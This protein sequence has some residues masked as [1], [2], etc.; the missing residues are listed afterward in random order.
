MVAK[1][2]W[3][4]ARTFS[5]MRTYR[6]ILC[7]IVRYRSWPM[8]INTCALSRAFTVE[9]KRL[10]MSAQI[11]HFIRHGEGYHNV[12]GRKSTEEYKKE[13]YADAHLTEL[14]WTQV[15]RYL[16]SRLDP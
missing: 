4:I 6:C 12:A 9:Y 7:A 16:S 5:P 1:I 2:Q 14:G 11:V 8:H 13:D 15:S 10:L 3:Q